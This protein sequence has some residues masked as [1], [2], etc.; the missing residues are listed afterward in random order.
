MKRM[1]NLIQFKKCDG[2]NKVS[3][4]SFRVEQWFQ[5]D[6]QYYLRMSIIKNR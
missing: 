3:R 4:N 5:M 6:K 2:M 1:Y